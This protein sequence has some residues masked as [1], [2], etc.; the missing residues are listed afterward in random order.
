MKKISLKCLLVAALL[1]ISVIQGIQAQPMAD[2]ADLHGKVTDAQGKPLGGVAITL[3]RGTDAGSAG[4]WG[5]VTYTDAHGEFEFAGADE[6]SYY[7]SVEATG[8][9]PVQNQQIA[10]AAHGKPL[11]YSLQLLGV[12]PLRVKDPN[13]AALS[14]QNFPLG[15]SSTDNGAYYQ[16]VPQVGDAGAVTVTGVV[17]GVGRG[18]G[19]QN[20]GVIENGITI[21]NAFA[22]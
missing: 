17:P 8:F 13:G 16:F 2:K 11:T 14:K 4:F 5:G 20:F 3:R 21:G 19:I 22:G 12:Q 10:L 6:G 7:V 18:E 1:S 15:L 9:A